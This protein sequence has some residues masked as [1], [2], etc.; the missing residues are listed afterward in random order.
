MNKTTASAIVFAL[1]APYPA[2]ADTSQDRAAP[3][4][5]EAAVESASD[6]STCPMVRSNGSEPESDC[7]GQPRMRSATATDYNSSRSNRHTSRGSE[8]DGDGDPEVA[9]ANHNTTRSNKTAPV[10]A[11]GDEDG[12]NDSSAKQK[13]VFRQDF[14]PVQTP[15]RVVSGGNAGGGASEQKDAERQTPPED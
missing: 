1:A 5:T 10:A 8:M 15:E 3:A 14:G 12:P 13:T 9:P 4:T 11:T 7:G 2:I 6:T